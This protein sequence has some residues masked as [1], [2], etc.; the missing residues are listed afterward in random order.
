MEKLKE[1]LDILEHESDSVYE[2]VT[3]APIQELK[4]DMG[5]Y[6]AICNTI[7]FVKCLMGDIE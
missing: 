4:Y 6:V 2:R 1:L 5:Y 7:V 3:Y